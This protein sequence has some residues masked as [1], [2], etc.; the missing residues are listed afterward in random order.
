MGSVGDSY[1]NALA[2]DLWILIKPRGLR[3]RTFATRAKV[4]LRH[5]EYIDGSQFCQQPAPPES[6]QR[7]SVIVQ[8]A[9]VGAVP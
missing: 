7:D 6:P 2:A 1:D 8:H 4:N 3:G 5:F 9:E